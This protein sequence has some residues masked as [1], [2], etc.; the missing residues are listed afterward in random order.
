MTLYRVLLGIILST[1]NLSADHTPSLCC[2]RHRALGGARLFMW[3]AAG[4]PRARG[5]TST[6]PSSMASGPSRKPVPGPPSVISVSS[7]STASG[8]SGPGHSLAKRSRQPIGGA[9]G[10]SAAD[11]IVIDS[12]EDEP[13]EVPRPRPVSKPS[14]SRPASVTVP[15]PRERTSSVDRRAPAAWGLFSHAKKPAQRPTTTLNHD[16]SAIKH[17]TPVEMA[18]TTSKSSSGSSSGPLLLGALLSAARAGR[19]GGRSLGSHGN[20]KPMAP[21]VTAVPSTAPRREAMPVVSK[22]GGALSTARPHSGIGHSPLLPSTVSTNSVPQPR[23]HVDE[24]PMKRAKVPDPVNRA[25]STATARV[26]HSQKPSQRRDAYESDPAFQAHNIPKDPVATAASARPART[27][28]HAGQYTIPPE[29]TPMREWPSTQGVITGTGKKSSIKPTSLGTQRSPSQATSNTL[30]PQNRHVVLPS[31]SRLHSHSRRRHLSPVKADAS[32]PSYFSSSSLSPI[33]TDSASPLPSDLS[34]TPKQQVGS[35][36]TP[37]VDDRTSGS[38]PF[39]RSAPSIRVEGPAD[40][41]PAKPVA[42]FDPV[43]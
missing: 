21:P 12:E 27:T 32:L 2:G 28:H 38:D 43:S 20:T 11:P 4:A 41:E 33:S 24:P 23:V 22:H 35:S 15:R 30:P 1:C 26:S 37:A 19:D 29:D 8:L 14:Q 31:P 9:I 7:T 10:T 17:E 6:H 3:P 25:R 13:L 18:R 5:S 16:R 39:R 34:V 42:E 36:G 40:A